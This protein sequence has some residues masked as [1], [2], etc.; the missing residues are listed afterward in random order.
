MNDP[1][2]PELAAVWGSLPNIKQKTKY[3]W[4]SACPK[5]GGDDRFIMRPDGTGKTGKARGW[6][7]GCGYSKFANSLIEKIGPDDLA[8]ITRKAKEDYKVRQEQRKREVEHALDW[9]R[10][11]DFWVKAHDLMTEEQRQVWRN[12][13]IVDPMQDQWKLGYLEQSKV[14]VNGQ[15]EAYPAMTIPHFNTEAEIANLQRRFIGQPDTIGKYRYMAK[16]PPVSFLT[17]FRPLKGP[18]V[19]VEGAIKAMVVYQH[20]AHEYDTV[21][22]LPSKTPGDEALDVLRDCEPIYLALDPD[23]YIVDG[24]SFYNQGTT[25]PAVL[26]IGKRLG[27]ERVRFVHL[28]DKPD[29][30]LRFYGASYS[31]MIDWIRR[32]SK[33]L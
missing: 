31:D 7:R 6:C 24:G 27:L 3:E 26:T 12:R 13:G 5:C 30:L 25:E 14:K 32:A 33:T 18:A 1:L 11:Q 9:L 28:V 2:P 23:A 4:S 22:G 20:I 29:D 8:E 19:V 16:L 17:E 21:I 15:I 10:H